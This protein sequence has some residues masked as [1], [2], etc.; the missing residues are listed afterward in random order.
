MRRHAGRHVAR[1]RQAGLAG[2]RGRGLAAGR[3][4]VR[5]EPRHEGRARGER[6]GGEGQGQ[7]RVGFGAVSGCIFVLLNEAQYVRMSKVLC[8]IVT[9]SLR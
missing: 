2:I 5:H 9:H 4:R 3:Q 7:K 1:L 8:N 6:D